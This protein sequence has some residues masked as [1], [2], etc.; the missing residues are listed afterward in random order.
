MFDDLLTKLIYILPGVIIALSFHEFAHSYVAYKLGDVRQKDSGRLSLN[1]LHH[2]DPFGTLCLFLTGFG[3]AKP[4]QVDPY[5]FKDRKNGMIYSSMAGPVANLIL[6]FLCILMM[7]ILGKTMTTFIYFN[8]IGSYLYQLLLYTS[9]INIGLGV[10]NLIPI[11]PLD[12][13]KIL[14]GIVK[15]ETYFKIMQ[16]EQYVSILL[17]L[18]LVTGAL[19]GPLVHARSTIMDAFVSFADM[20]TPFL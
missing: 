2:L 1:P 9:M 14:L 7:V 17:I 10:F 19:N 16:Y 6:G 11:P 4:V 12:G 15:E 13:S 5:F 18:V 3:W 20:I 8:S